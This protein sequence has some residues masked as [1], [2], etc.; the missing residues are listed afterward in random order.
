MNEQRISPHLVKALQD[1]WCEETGGSFYPDNPSKNQCAVT[2]LVVQD[3]YGGSLVRGHVGDISHYWNELEDGT[4]VDLT[5]QQFGNRV[6]ELVRDFYRSRHYVLTA[7]ETV[8]ARYS[9]L[10]YLVLD[11]LYNNVLV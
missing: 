1:S 8:R 3:F 2:A 4:E 7:N 11:K 6:G 10:K 5:R 9:K